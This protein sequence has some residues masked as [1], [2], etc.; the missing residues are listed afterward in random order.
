[1]PS[2][3]FRILFICSVYLS[4][5]TWTG[6]GS[7]TIGGIV[8]EAPWKITYSCTSGKGFIFVSV[9]RGEELIESTNSIDGEEQT[10]DI[11]AKGVFRVKVASACK[12]EVRVSD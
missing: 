4:A 7:R 1:M 10:T 2:S 6:S 11:D 12:W 3:F 9:Y 8:R 5:E